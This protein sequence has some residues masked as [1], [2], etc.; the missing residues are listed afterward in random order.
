MKCILAGRGSGV[1]KQQVER[2]HDSGSS[3]QTQDVSF[4]RCNSRGIVGTAQV[5]AAANSLASSRRHCTCNSVQRKILA[6]PSPGTS[7]EGG[8]SSG[9]L[10]R[11]KQAFGYYFRFPLHNKATFKKI[12]FPRTKQTKNP[13][14]RADI[15]LC[16]LGGSF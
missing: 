9:G 15:T 4:K 14:E 2:G 11:G 6:S 5:R 7:R 3:V 16:G 12:L 1:R 8:S 10:H 13:K